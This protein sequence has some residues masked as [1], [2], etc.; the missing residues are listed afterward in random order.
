M[1]QQQTIAAPIE[2]SG[3]GIH[4]GKPVHLSLLPRDQGDILFRRTDLDG[5][6]FVVDPQEI[7]CRNSSILLKGEHQIYTLEHL[8]AAFYAYEIDSVLVEL[9]GEEIPILDGSA[10]L[11]VQALDRA[12]KRPLSGAIKTIRV[13]ESLLVEE[14]EAWVSVSPHES[15]EVTYTIDFDHPLIGIQKLSL[16][17]EPPG[18]RRE[19]APARTFG[20][21]RDVP[22]L[23]ARHLA[24][25]GST[26]NAL[27]LD[28]SSLINGPLRFPDEFVRHKIL[29]LIGDFS[30]LGFPIQA[31]LEA[32]KAGHSLH[33]KAVRHILDHPELWLLE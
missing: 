4:T 25:G 28:D 21:L 29:D 3:I 27:V 6:E 5:L 22:E 30:L 18:F 2:M 33:L 19:V 17:V 23:H 32:F 14:K 11:W 7:A 12:G 16:E 8:L 26:S 31:K 15:F 10:L 13:L 20:F 9:D 1:R 24:M